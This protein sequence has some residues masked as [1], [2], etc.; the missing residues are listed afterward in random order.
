[1]SASASPADPLATG[2]A[3]AVGAGRVGMGLG[4]ALFTRPAL[5]L[6]GFERPSGATVALARLAGMRDVAIGAHALAGG[7]DRDRLREATLI[8]AM[9][10]ASDALAFSAAL[11][12]RDGIDATA[13]KNAPGAA[14]AAAL[15]AWI[16]SRL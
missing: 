10:D 9:V 3:L 16:L 13:A 1:M 12:S 11:A 15:G 8:G 7:T 14:A 4:I 5:G 6:L 2:A